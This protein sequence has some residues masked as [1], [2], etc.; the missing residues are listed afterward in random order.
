MRFK[1]T[2]S[3]FISS[4]QTRSI[5]AKKNII[6]SFGLK[7]ISILI[8]LAYVSLLINALGKEEYGI[9]LILTSFM[10]WIAFFDIGIGNGTRNY[11]GKALAKKDY[12]KA[13]SYVS[14]TYAIF[15][16]IFLPLIVVILIVTPFI[17]WQS[18]F[19]TNAVNEQT[20]KVV[21]SVVLSFFALRLIFQTINILLLADQR[22]AMTGLIGLI[23]NVISFALIYLLNSIGYNSFILFCTILCIVPVFVFIVYSFILFSKSYKHLRPSFKSVDFNL[24][25]NILSLGLKFFII[26]IS[27]IIIYTSTNLIITQFYNPE[28]VTSYNIAYKYFSVI[29]MFYGIV[30]TPLWSSVTDA[31]A[32]EDMKWMKNILKKYNYISVLLIVAILIMFLASPFIYQWWVPSVEIS[33]SLSLVVA[34]QALMYVVFT[35][36]I[37]LLNGVGK[38][39]LVMYFVIVQSIVYIPLVFLF[40]KYLA[41]GVA[42]I[43]LVSIVIEIPLKITQFIQ[44]KKIINQTAKGIWNE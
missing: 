32:L 38:I 31:Y 16:L 22:P 8:S 33:S 26:Q 36:Y 7:G 29:T 28:S 3:K 30:I 20:L 15:I 2:I 12:E 14:T 21:A 42:G 5:K 40:D 39:K 34:L 44:T 37:T 6:A 19:N 24:T 25:K 10:S 4:G 23:S 41:I 17:H 43:L 18:V 13:K 1:S 11:L 9:W 27:G 35:P